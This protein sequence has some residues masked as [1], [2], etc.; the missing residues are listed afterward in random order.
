MENY[1]DADVFL[2]QLEQKKF[3]EEAIG[4]FQKQFE[5]LVVL[6]YIIRNTGGNIKMP[7][8]DLIVVRI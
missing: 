1:I 4:K 5:R 6:D 8:I 2:Q 7:E 3:P